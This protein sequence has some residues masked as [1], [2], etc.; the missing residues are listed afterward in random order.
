MADEPTNSSVMTPEQRLKRLDDLEQRQIQA[1]RNA[2]RG[3]WISV[4]IA[5]LVFFGIIAAGTWQ[6]RE[7]EAHRNDLILQNRSLGARLAA[8]R[9]EA[10]KAEA[11]ARAYRGV[12][13]KLSDSERKDAVEKQVSAVPQSAALL[14]RIYMQIV[15]SEDRTRAESIRKTLEQAGY[16][17]LGIELVEKAAGT[18]KVSDVRYYRDDDA[19]QAQRIADLLEKAGESN[20]K[21][22]IPAGKKDSPNV[23]PNHYEIWLAHH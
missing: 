23:R 10:V 4:C 6:V 18:Q 22:F 9:K 13:D 8:A 15:N 21:V 20:V 19:K 17:V 11:S 7:L 12:V 3:A 2:V 14:P 1:H 16:L 5:A